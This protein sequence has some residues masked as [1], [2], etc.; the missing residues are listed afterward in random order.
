MTGTVHTRVV[1]R[2]CEVVGSSRLA[3]RVDV[4]HAMVQSWLGGKAAPPA[5][6]FLRILN[7]LRAVDPGYRP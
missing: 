6:V 4:S 1:R 3:E 7:L 5:R 2:A